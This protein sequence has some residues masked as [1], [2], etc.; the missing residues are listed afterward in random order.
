[1]LK[2]NDTEPESPQE[3]PLKKSEKQKP[4]IKLVSLDEKQNKKEKE[5]G[6]KKVPKE[7]SLER[8]TVTTT[9]PIPII[10]YIRDISADS[11]NIY[12]CQKTVA[13]LLEE[14]CKAVIENAIKSNSGN[15][16]ALRTENLKRGRPR[17]Q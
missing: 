11:L 5:A 6:K 7:L 8:E 15:G 17:K 4:K 14:G 10:D 1:M 16:I 12:G 2:I 13:A 3:I 9:L